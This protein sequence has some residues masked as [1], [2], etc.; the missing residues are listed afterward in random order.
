MAEPVG[1]GCSFDEDFIDLL[2]LNGYRVAKAGRSD[3][4]GSQIAA[5]RIDEVGQ[6]IA[7]IIHHIES[8]VP[9]TE[10]DLDG[11]ERRSE[12]LPGRITVLLSPSAGFSRSATDLAARRGVRLWGPREVD[13]LR[14][15]VAEK[16]GLRQRREVDRPVIGA[17]GK[18]R[19]SKAKAA[20]LLLLFLAAALLYAKTG[21]IDLPVGLSDLAGE[22]ES[23]DLA[24][25]LRSRAPLV[26]EAALGLS[27]TISGLIRG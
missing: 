11:I 17:K 2:E 5:S 20:V 8:E 22:V 24:G 16:R 21:G 1:G 10:E 25:V 18:R 27:E 12:K 19:R 9:L 13:R 4:G 3:G 23:T 14:R 7:Y 6:E 26:R 15:N